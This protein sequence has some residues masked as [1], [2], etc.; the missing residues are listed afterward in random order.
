M[1]ALT[2]LMGLVEPKLLVRM[3]W[4]PAALADG[5]DRAAGDHAGAR[6]GRHQHHAGGAEVAR[7]PGA[8]W[9]SR[10][11][12]TSIMLRHAVL[13]GLF[14]GGRHFVGLAV[15]PADLA[16]AVADHDQGAKLKRR[17]P[18]TTAA[19]RRILMTFSISSP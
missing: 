2:R 16:A 19:Q 15:A 11:M 13:D 6:A 12:G 8:E 9:W 3:S 17:P 14:H 5:P 7:R 18:L 1:V 4:M 10:R